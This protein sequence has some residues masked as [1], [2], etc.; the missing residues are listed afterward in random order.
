MAKLSISFSEKVDDDELERIKMRCDLQDISWDEFGYTFIINEH[1]AF[2]GH[3]AE[4]DYRMFRIR[5]VL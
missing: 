1:L 3:V 4:E 2:E 5:E